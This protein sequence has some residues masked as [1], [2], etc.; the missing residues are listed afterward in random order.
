MFKGSHLFQTIILGPSMLVFGG[1]RIWWQQRCCWGETM[2]IDLEWMNK[3]KIRLHDCMM[4][5]YCWFQTWAKTTS[6]CSSLLYIYLY[7]YI[8]IDYM[9]TQFVFFFLLGR[10]PGFPRYHSHDGTPYESGQS[11]YV[12]CY[13]KSHPGL[14]LRSSTWPI[15][16]WAAFKTLVT[17]HYTDWFIGILIMAS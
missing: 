8:Y 17:F 4:I 7:I 11:V 14:V 1:V 15:E 5:K 9:H 3:N 6:N 10:F 2:K 16:T 12:S 13:S